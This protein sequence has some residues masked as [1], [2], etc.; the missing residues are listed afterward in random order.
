MSRIT[1]VIGWPTMSEIYWVPFPTIRDNVAKYRR[2]YWALN[3]A[4]E[5]SNDCRLNNAVYTLILQAQKKR[6]EST[7][8][9]VRIKVHRHII[10]LEDALKRAGNLFES[11]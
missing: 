4:M 9:N 2:L 6:N 3:N 11:I 5:M 10:P 8:Q 7:M 1:D